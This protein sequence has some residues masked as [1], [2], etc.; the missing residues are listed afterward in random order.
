M[1]RRQRDPFVT[2]REAAASRV[3]SLSTLKRL[4]RRGVLTRYKQ[5]GRRETFL[6]RSELEQVL[7]PKAS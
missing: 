4:L 7:Q 1:K 2:I 6:L 3:T 5:P